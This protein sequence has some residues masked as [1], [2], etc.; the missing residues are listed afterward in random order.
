M[1]VGKQVTD[2]LGVNFYVNNVFDKVHPR[3]DGFNSY[4]YFWRAFSPIGREVAL[5]L[6]YKFN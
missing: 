3:D 5:E 2:K 4:P 1:S 6:E